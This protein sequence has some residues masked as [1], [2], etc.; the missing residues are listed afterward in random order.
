MPPFSL[1]LRN[2][3]KGAFLRSGDP[4]IWLHEKNRRSRIGAALVL[5][6]GAAADADGADD[7]PIFVLQK[8]TAGEKDDAVV[9]HFDAIEG[10]TG[11]G[12][13]AEL[14]GGHVEEAAVFAFLMEISAL[15]MN[16]PS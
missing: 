4:A 5:V 1:L 16:A 13:G 14:T 6:D 3:E 10:T 8:N 2:E 15:P 9:G 7:D 11:K 12:C